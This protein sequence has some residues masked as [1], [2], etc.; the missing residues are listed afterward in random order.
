S[1]FELFERE[2]NEIRDLE[3]APFGHNVRQHAQI[4]CLG[5]GQDRIMITVLLN[6]ETALEKTVTPTGA[7]SM[8]PPFISGTQNT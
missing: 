4:I 3:I 7:M 8:V 6:P 1:Y 5:T 2:T